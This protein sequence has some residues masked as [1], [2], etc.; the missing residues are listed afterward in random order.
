MPA[1]P[2]DQQCQ[3]RKGQHAC[4]HGNLLHGGVFGRG[5]LCGLRLSGLL[6]GNPLRLGSD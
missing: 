2:A 1:P 4:G 6:G 5:G 3:Q